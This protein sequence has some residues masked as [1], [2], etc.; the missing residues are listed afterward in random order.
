[1]KSLFLLALSLTSLVATAQSKKTEDFHLDKEYKLN[2]DGIIY[3]NASDAKVTITG[4]SRTTAH[5][6]ID[7][8]ITTQGIVF[9]GREFTVDVTEENGNLSVKE[10]FSGTT[11]NMGGYHSERYT[12][13]IE[14][15]EGASLVIRGDDGDYSVEAVNGSIDL[16]MDDADVDL[17]GCK[18]NSFRIKMDDGD[19]R[20]D[21]GRGLLEVDADD[22]DVDI[23]NAS[24]ERISARLDDGD[25]IVETALAA[26]G[27]YSI[28][29]KDGSIVLTVRNGGGRFDIRHDDTSVVADGSFDEVEKSESRTRLILDGG[30]AK[31]DI[32][33]D[34]AR[35]RLAKN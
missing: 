25:F 32:R 30:N 7:R 8:E 13:K 34:D 2:S 4:S 24:F 9:G 10:R 20:M 17:I 19:L 22:G 6:K 31:I 11:V 35:V 14:A 18:G 28:H 26:N 21:T 3:L 16:N 12:I 29:V 15:P 5:V 1:M 27:E 23:K 33:T